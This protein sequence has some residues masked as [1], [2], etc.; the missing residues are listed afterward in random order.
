[1]RWY[2]AAIVVPII[3][4]PSGLFGQGVFGGN[5]TDRKHR[6]IAGKPCLQSS[7]S[8]TPLASN[9]RIQNHLVSLDNHCPAQIKAKV[10]YY[11]T[12]ECTDVA[13]PG[14]SHREQVIGVFPAI[15][16]FRYEV[17]EQF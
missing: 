8:A 3:L 4:L 2:A 9:P 12:D 10:C 13:V 15:Q 1:M 11:G 14:Y 17:K 16:Q 6:D 5:V 7:G